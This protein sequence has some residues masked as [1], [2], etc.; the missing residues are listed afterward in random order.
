MGR[1]ALT[2]MGIVAK[3]NGMEFPGATARVT[4][5]MVSTPLRR[6]GRLV[7]DI[8]FGKSLPAEDRVRMENAALTCPVKQSLHPD[9]E[10]PMTFHWPE[11]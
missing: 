1:R 3:R 6:V 9:V 2:T 4:K 8:T 7:V 10:A 11:Q 5:E